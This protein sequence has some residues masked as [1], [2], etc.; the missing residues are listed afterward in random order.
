VGR[1]GMMDGSL[2]REQEE[3][4][5][6]VCVYICWGGYLERGVNG[7]LTYH[8]GNNDCFLLTRYGG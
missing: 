7:L 2:G 6:E 8:E 4:V 5:Q 3:G 1:L